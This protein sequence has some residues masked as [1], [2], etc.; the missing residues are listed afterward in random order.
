VSAVLKL[1]SDVV[2]QMVLGEAHQASNISGERRSVNLGQSY[3]LNCLIEG[4]NPPPNV[5]L[6]S[7]LGG[8]KAFEGVVVTQKTDR[9]ADRR[10][11]V[12]WHLMNATLHWT[13]TAHDIGRPLV[14]SAGVD[15]HRAVWA[16]F[17]PIVDTS[18]LPPQH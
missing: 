13:A 14:C 16:Q 6:A 17:V 4:G 1:D 15:N 5:T 7:G 12:P 8:G 18:K 3:V 9:N 2:G 10:L 11:S